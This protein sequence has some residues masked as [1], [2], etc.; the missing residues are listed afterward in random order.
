MIWKKHCEKKK[1]CVINMSHKEVEIYVVI[2]NILRFRFD[3]VRKNF[4]AL[5]LKLG[6]NKLRV[7]LIH[8]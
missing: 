2:I 5:L 4:R 1:I 3:N 7:Y 6:Q 8:K